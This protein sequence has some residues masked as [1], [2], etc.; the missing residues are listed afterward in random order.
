MILYHRDGSVFT[1]KDAYDFLSERINELF[2]NVKDKY[3]LCVDISDA[4]SVHSGNISTYLKKRVSDSLIKVELGLREF[5]AKDDKPA[6]VYDFVGSLVTMYNEK[7]HVDQFIRYYKSKNLLDRFMCVSYCACYLNDDYYRQNYFTNPCEVNAQEHG[8]VGAYDILCQFCTKY[9]ANML[10]CEYQ[11]RRS[12]TGHD[13]L[14]SCNGRLHRNVF[15]IINDFDSLYVDSLHSTR[16]Y[17]IDQNSDDVALDKSKW[18]VKVGD[19]LQQFLAETDGFKQDLMIASMSMGDNIIFRQAKRHMKSIAGISFRSSVVFKTFGFVSV[20]KNK[21]QALL[22]R[23]ALYNRCLKSWNETIPDHED[24]IRI[25]K[26][27]F[28]EEVCDHPEW[29]VEN[30]S[31]FKGSEVR[32]AYYRSHGLDNCSD[33]PGGDE[34][35]ERDVLSGK[36]RD[37]STSFSFDMKQEDAYIYK[38][39]ENGRFVPE[40]D[41][42]HMFYLHPKVRFICY[43]VLS[44]VYGFLYSWHPDPLNDPWSPDARCYVS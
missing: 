36:Q 23:R 34:A 13:F 27:T 28:E 12:A 42:Y 15:Y 39:L 29:K 25:S 17:D 6:D 24:L 9:V 37:E 10:I 1:N 40:F 43:E 41:F 11:N 26:R 22:E 32:L 16:K 8:I 44:M 30:S 7:E 3:G 33:Y 35:F 19:Y 4:R 20:L 18:S 2:V 5:A 14:L 31:R 38:C 21:V